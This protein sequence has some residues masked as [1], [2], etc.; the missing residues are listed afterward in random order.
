MVDQKDNDSKKNQEKIAI[1]R[2]RGSVRVRHDI[3]LTLKLL[4]FLLL[5]FVG[6]TDQVHYIH[7]PL[8]NS[9]F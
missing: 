6:T 4:N 8:R 3:V 7:I 2:I 1:I 9:K 5:F